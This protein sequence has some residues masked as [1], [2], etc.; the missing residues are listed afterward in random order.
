MG[1]V[2]SSKLIGKEDGSDFH[3]TQTSIVV[4]GNSKEA[5]NS[6]A[7]IADKIGD[8]KTKDN[9]GVKDDKRKSNDKSGKNA[10]QK[11]GA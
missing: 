5:T 11:K 10:G 7:A 9:G 6:S 2:D 8:R 4:G 3:N 1:N